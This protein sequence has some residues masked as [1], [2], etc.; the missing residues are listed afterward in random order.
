VE[1]LKVKF[2]MT[3]ASTIRTGAATAERPEEIQK[4]RE[5]ETQKSVPREMRMDRDTERA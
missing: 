3:L 1:I 4:T 5:K 2:N